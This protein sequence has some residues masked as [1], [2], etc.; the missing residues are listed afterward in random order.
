MISK[1]ESHSRRCSTTLNIGSKTLSK[2]VS[3]TQQRLPNTRSNSSQVIGVSVNLDR[4]KYGIARGITAPEKVKEVSRS[5]TS[6][7]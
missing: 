2:H 3:H 7:I 5:L 6:N 4:K 1:E